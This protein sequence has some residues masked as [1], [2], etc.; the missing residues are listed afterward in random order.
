MDSGLMIATIVI[1]LVYLIIYSSL[2]LFTLLKF[3]F[4]IDLSAKITLLLFFLVFLLRLIAWS[5]YHSRS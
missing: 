1:D 4:K 5:I 3:K 2:T